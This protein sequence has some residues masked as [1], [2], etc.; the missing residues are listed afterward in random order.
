MLPSSA[1]PAPRTERDTRFLV[2]QDLEGRWIA[3]ETHGRGGGLFRS[4]ADALHYAKSETSGRVD[5]VTLSAE[6]ITV[7]L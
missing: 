5:A 3:V 2:G 7:S 6:P 4:C 1:S